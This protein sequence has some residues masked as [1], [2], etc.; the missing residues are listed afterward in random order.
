MV[1][2]EYLSTD[3][4]FNDT[5]LDLEINKFEGWREKILLAVIVR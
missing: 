2:T 3:L 5:S 4:S 1:H